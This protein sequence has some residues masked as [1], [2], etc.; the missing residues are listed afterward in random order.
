MHKHKIFI[1]SVQKE[2]S[3]ER[4]AIKDFVNGDALCRRYFDIFLFEDIP[5]RDRNPDSVYLEEVKKCDVYVCLLGNEYGIQDRQG[6][7]ATEHEFH[8]A[9]K[10]GKIR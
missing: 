6:I 8:E 2:F 7:S 5:A 1:S 4:Q 3:A 9:T 10:L